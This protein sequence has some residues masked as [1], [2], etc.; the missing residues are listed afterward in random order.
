MFL[1]SKKISPLLLVLIALMFEANRHSAQGLK[2]WGC[3]DFVQNRPDPPTCVFALVNCTDDGACAKAKWLHGEG[4]L[5]YYCQRD[6][7]LWQNSDGNPICIANEKCFC[8]NEDNCNKEKDFCTGKG[9]DPCLGTRNGE[10]G[11]QEKGDGGDD[12]KGDEDGKKGGGKGLVPVTAVSMLS[13]AISTVAVT[14]GRF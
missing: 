13:F 11:S 5:A 9:K 10:D 6:P 2:C 8:N 4:E 1:F 3:A 12:D 7:T 14:L